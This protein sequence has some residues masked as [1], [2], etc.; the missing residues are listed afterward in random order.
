MRMNAR[1]RTWMGGAAAAAALLTVAGCGANSG[2]TNNGA[3]SSTSGSANSA[4]TSN[5]SGAQSGSAKTVKLNETGSSL[6]YPLFNGQWIPAYQSAHP[7]VQLSAAST[8]SGKGISDA[9]Q[10]LVQIGGSDAY[11]ADAQM[12]QNSSMLNI[13]LA[14][15]AQQIMYNVPE[16]GK[17][18]LR[19][20]GNVL[21]KIYTGQITYWDDAAIKSLNPGVQLPHQK[22]VVVRRSDASG[23]TFLFTQYLSDNNAQWKSKYGFGTDVSWPAVN[24]EIGAKGN[25]GVVTALEK[26]KYSIGYVG[27]SWL[28]QATSGGLG[29]AALKNHDGQ[30]VLPS[31]AT[32]EN[33]ASAMV[34][35]VPADERIS[36]I[37]APGPNS[38]PIINFEYAIVNSKQ[39]DPTTAKALKNF[40]QWAIDPA[41][42]NDAKYLSPVHFQPLPQN[43]ENKTKAQIAKIQG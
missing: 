28:D 24:G 8:G 9:M 14:I 17:K 12:Q 3:N 6:L 2:N 11:L 22:I 13:P 25:D 32:I 39:A 33:A 5:Q 23:D 30:F 35:K 42:G 18:H 41:G 20:D 19:L 34:S 1:M 29:Y 21:A 43:L 26:N 36:L 40:L 27:I 16:A 10:G 7:N 15:S 31:A 38:Y 37:D 4:N